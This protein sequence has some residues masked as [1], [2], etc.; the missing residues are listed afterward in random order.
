MELFSIMFFILIS[1]VS[2]LSYKIDKKTSLDMRKEQ[3]TRNFRDS[4]IKKIF[5]ENFEENVSYSK[6]HKVE[7][8][9]I[10]AGFKIKYCEY[11]IICI[12]SSILFPFISFLILKNEFLSFA[13]IFLGY[14][15]PSQVISFFRNKRMLALD[16]QIGSFLNMVT[17]RYVNTKDFSKAIQDCVED[18]RGS[19]P[20]YTE[21]RDTVLEIQLGVPTA[22]AVKNLSIRTGS[23]YIN[24]LS[25]YY[26]LALRLG[27]V[28][29]RNT[30]LKQAF[31]QYEEDRKIK[32]NL[33]MAI[34]GPTNVAYIMIGFIPAT[35][36]YSCF[37]NPDYL[38]FM[39]ETL[40]GKVGMTFIV[41][42]V[43]LSLWLVNTK[44][45]AP[46][47]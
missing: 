24:R 10:Q 3:T 43:I 39:T 32:S 11:K 23:K 41:S 16:S 7:T 46:I 1:L 4:S 36:I 30:L 5:E 37:T 40:L 34:S 22:E 31:Y 47:D 28:E 21:L 6:K 29:A 19:E 2:I 9:C 13:F 25:D 45:S 44:I 14:T 8:M 20:L 18:F 15:I 26:A 27:T 17:E 12:A 33:K 42:V 35:I 38:P